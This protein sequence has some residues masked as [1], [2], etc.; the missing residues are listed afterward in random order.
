MKPSA[1]IAT[2]S[3]RSRR[4]NSCIGERA[5]IFAS[6]ARVADDDASVVR[7]VHEPGGIAGAHG[8]ASRVRVLRW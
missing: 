7:L 2:L 3:R 6:P 4:Q 5:A 8:R 1:T